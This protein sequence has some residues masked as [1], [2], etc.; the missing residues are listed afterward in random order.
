MTWTIKLSYLLYT[1]SLIA[2]NTYLPRQ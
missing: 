2:D 1:A